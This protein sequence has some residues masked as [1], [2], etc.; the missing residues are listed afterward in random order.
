MRFAAI[1]DIHG[2]CLALEAVLNDIAAQGIHDVV[3]L[4][5][6][7]SGPL[8][9]AKTAD[10]LMRREC[11]TIRGNHDRYL[12]ELERASMWPSDR[13]AHDQLEPHHIAWLKSL[14]ATARFR[15]EV[16]LCHATPDDDNTYWLETVMADGRVCATPIEEIEARASGI[17]A[18]LILC[19]HTHIPRT[20]RLRDG[21]LIVNPGSV[22]CPGY[23]DVVPVPHRMEAATPDACYA[24]LERTPRGWS[25]TFRLVPYDHMAMA[26][27]AR[28]NG[29]HEWGSALASGWLR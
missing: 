3:N 7:L 23:T 8:E 15:D 10:L 5:D 21:R 26:E 27:L 1:A 25:T 11:T 28:R 29:R 22:G 24:I 12:I 19:G 9:A 14:P 16:F 20:A 13:L 17:E 6:H 2:N 18:S 4:G